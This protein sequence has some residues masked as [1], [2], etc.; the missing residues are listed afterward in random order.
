MLK[1]QIFTSDTRFKYFDYYF[2]E[3]TYRI[4]LRK[5]FTWANL[6]E[7]LVLETTKSWEKKKTVQVA[8]MDVEEWFEHRGK[9]SDIFWSLWIG[10]AVK[11]GTHIED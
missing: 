3:I 10:K 4:T 7:F 5:P 11:Q 1:S 2:W 6:I 9:T 8:G